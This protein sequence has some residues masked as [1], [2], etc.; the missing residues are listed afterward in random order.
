MQPYA[1]GTLVIV[2]DCADLNRASTFWCDVLGY[3]RPLTPSGPYVNLVSPEGGIELLLQQVP[4][5]KSGKNR[6]HLD[7]R[8]RDLD[9]AEVQR[10]VA[11]GAVTLTQ[12]PL[13][14][15][16]WQ[17]HV[18]VDATATS[19]ASSNRPTTSPWPA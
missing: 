15:H 14:E 1:H 11:L 6:L 7:L 12:A 2:L 8:T 13:E 19:S 5:R 17:W 10:V 4:E 3:N 9:E 16:A 18:L